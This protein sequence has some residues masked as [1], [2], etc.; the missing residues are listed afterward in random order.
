[1]E[2]KFVNIDIVHAF[3]KI[4]LEV[5]TQEQWCINFFHVLPLWLRSIQE[6]VALFIQNTMRTGLGIICGRVLF[7]MLKLP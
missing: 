3:P 1:M 2:G 4:V 5:C 6:C 7:S